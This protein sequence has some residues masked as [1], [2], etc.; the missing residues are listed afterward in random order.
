[1]FLDL[2]KN[3]LIISFKKCIKSIFKNDFKAMKNKDISKYFSHIMQSR[4]KDFQDTVDRLC[5]I[6]T[7]VHIEGQ[8]DK[9]LKKIL[10][11]LN[12]WY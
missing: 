5:N 4:S 11:L 3:I 8:K 2:Y 10:D 1:M 7:Y 6:F 12:G 9:K